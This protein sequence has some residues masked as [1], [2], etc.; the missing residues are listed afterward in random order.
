MMADGSFP[1]DLVTG[2]PAYK[3]RVA[4]PYLDCS[5]VPPFSEKVLT[6]MAA[7]AKEMLAAMPDYDVE[8]AFESLMSRTNCGGPG[9]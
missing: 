3:R 7:L 4:L 8:R 6:M 9:N 1:C 5:V 2:A